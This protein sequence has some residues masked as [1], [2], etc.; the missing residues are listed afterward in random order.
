M[1]WEVRI[2]SPHT[3]SLCFCHSCDRQTNALFKDEAKKDVVCSQCRGDFV[4]L[5][6]NNES[7]SS[8]TNNKN[9]DND[10]RASNSSFVM[11]ENT[12]AT[13]GPSNQGSTSD[14]ASSSSSTTATCCSTSSSTSSSTSASSSNSASFLSQ[15]HLFFAALETPIRALFELIDDSVDQLVVAP[16][17]RGHASSKHHAR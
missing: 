16:L 3:M 17:N 6:C 5:A 7:S 2:S 11:L 14:T 13:V 1:V 9:D 15:P 10:L 12:T 4:E 8:G